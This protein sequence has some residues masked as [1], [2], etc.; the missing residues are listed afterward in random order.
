[1]RSYDV[2]TD[3]RNDSSSTD[4]DVVGAEW[5]TSSSRERATRASPDESDAITVITRR[6]NCGYGGDAVSVS[7]KSVGCAAGGKKPSQEGTPSGEGTARAGRLNSQLK[8]RYV[9]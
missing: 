9:Q 6:V 8:Y 2:D 7:V 5:S 4:S 1:V 3:W